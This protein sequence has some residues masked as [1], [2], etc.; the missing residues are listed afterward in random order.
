MNEPLDKTGRPNWLQRHPFLVILTVIVS[1]LMGLGIRDQEPQSTVVTTIALGMYGTVWLIG[2]VVMTFLARWIRKKR[3]KPPIPYRGSV[4]PDNVLQWIGRHKVW[5]VVIGVPF[6]MALIGTMRSADPLTNTV[7]LMLVWLLVIALV[8]FFTRLVVKDTQPRV[9]PLPANASPNGLG[10]PQ[11]PLDLPA[12][13]V[14]RLQDLVGL[15][16]A[17]FEQLCVR[18]LVATGYNDVRRCDNADPDGPDII[19]QDPQGRRVVVRCIRSAA[20][21]V[22]HTSALDHV[23]TVRTQNRVER[24]IILTTGLCTNEQHAF[25]AANNLLLVDGPQLLHALSLTAVPTALT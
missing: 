24:G 25:A 10:L 22:I 16:Q 21:R 9:I 18:L 12:E 20:G 2:L 7:A 1:V 4:F 11:R 6:V 19:A 8:A 5:A 13:Q 3:N 17:G 23:A 14:G 15:T